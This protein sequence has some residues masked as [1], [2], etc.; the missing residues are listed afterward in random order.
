MKYWQIEKRSAWP[1]EPVFETFIDEQLEAN[2]ALEAQ[3]VPSAGS[4]DIRKIRAFQRFNSDGS[5]KIPLLNHGSDDAIRTP[6]GE[7]PIRLFEVENPKGIYVHF[8]GGGWVMGSMHEQDNLLWEF[9]QSTQLTVISVDYPLAP[10]THLEKIIEAANN[11][12]F[13]LMEKYPQE[14]F[15][16]GGESAG[17]HIALNALFGVIPY[18]EKLARVV[19]LNLCY[20]IYD[21]SMTP[22]QRLWGDRML[23]LSTDYLEWFY[24]MALPDYSPEERRSPMV[25]PMY[26]D[27]IK[28]LPPVLFTVGEYDPLFDDSVFMA[29]RMRAA[30]NVAELCVYPKA[31]HGFNALNTQMG[32]AANQKIF[33]FVG[34][35]F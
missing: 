1:V 6:S 34:R 16:I 5:N 17:A 22:S 24:S 11:A 15:C 7:I 21:I 20:G 12:A 27:D 31:P 9:A 35:Y 14:L 23:G 10:E 30:G 3:K 33:E 25:S 2:A 13:A 29:S 4:V 28:G 19:V 18:P 32:K 26:R 8:H